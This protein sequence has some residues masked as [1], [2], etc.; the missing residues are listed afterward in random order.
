MFGQFGS[1]RSWLACMGLAA[2]V[3]SPAGLAADSV[4]NPSALLRQTW[5]LPAVDHPRFVRQLALLNQEAPR[6]TPDEQWRLR[7][8]NAWESMY[9]GEYARS[10]AQFH[11]VIEHSG[12]MALAA[13]A[14]ALFLSQLG[15][16]KHYEQA[17]ELANR[18]VA[19][20]PQI[21]DHE[22]R[23]AVLFNLSQAMGLAGQTDMAI[24]YARMMQDSVGSARDLCSS[25]AM[26]VEALFN[27]HRLKSS[28]PELPR[29]IDACT[30][31]GMPVFVE[32]D[33]LTLANVYLDEGQPAKALAL[34][35]RIEPGIRI[36]QYYNSRLSSQVE[37][38]QALAGL[39]DD[40]AA[41]KAALVA[42]AMNK[43][44]DINGWLKDVYEV[45]YQV[46]KREGHAAEALAYHERY[47]AQE[48]GYL[49][50]AGARMLAYQTV[51][52]HLLEQKLE[53]EKLS[54]QNAMLRMR[55][56]L[57]AKTVETNRL[58]LALLL[59]AL[60][61][62]VFWMFRL[63]RS[64]LRF[65]KLSHLDG[66]TTVFNR[67]HFMGEVERALRLLERR[68]DA[69][70]LVFIDLDHFKRINDTH[71]HAMGDEVLRHIV[72]VCRQHLRAADLFGRLG[73][74]EFGILL[75]ECSREEGVAIAERIRLA[76]ETGKVES[77]GVAIGVST[78]VGLAFTDA[79]GYDLQRLC[80][81][82][83]AALYRAKRS[84]RNRVVADIADDDLVEV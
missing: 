12:N 56:M 72:A 54:R 6:L 20:L 76:I 32:T 80:K 13:R 16:T 51:Q 14:S 19:E 30:I 1:L 50:D 17:F 48:K 9:E 84:G 18:L 75:V 7:Y 59:L 3:F 52:Q 79:S 24:R 58:Y 43:S 8:L 69:A 62:A 10:E 67:Q 44:S 41:K 31:A 28:S 71:G 60:G 4:A 74:E 27:G 63:K 57:D 65:K 23:F 83:D 40:E 22:V 45:L 39:G 29:A 46:E 37:R 35:D 70:C 68:V 38:A 25:R 5:P 55:Q 34:L 21:E 2:G 49:D 78:S 64:Q 81:E 82:A 66:L 77:D 53:T 11:D 26:L 33:W 73:G 15:L 36:H 61:F 47:A 42:V